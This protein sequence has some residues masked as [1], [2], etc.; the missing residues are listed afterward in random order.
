MKE[1]S[2]K[3]EKGTETVLSMESDFSSQAVSQRVPDAVRTTV[4]P[5]KAVFKRRSPDEEQ[6]VASDIFKRGLDWEEVQMF[7][8]A[9]SE[10]KNEN[11][12][13]V[14]DVHWSHYPHDILLTYCI[15]Y[16]LW[17][18]FHIF[19]TVPKFYKHSFEETAC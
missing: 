7:R 2:H 3:L 4:T 13:I 18:V 9:L 14:T 19:L 5:S 1:G 15:L 11:E 17:F 8:L 6:S 12:D 10:L 16:M